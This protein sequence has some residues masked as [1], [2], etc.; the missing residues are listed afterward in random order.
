MR[1]LPHAA[2]APPPTI[3]SAAGG[4]GPARCPHVN[5]R[6]PVLAVVQPA[7]PLILRHGRP[8]A[9]AAP[10]W[11]GHVQAL[12]VAH[13]AEHE[14]AAVPQQQGGGEARVMSRGVVQARR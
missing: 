6:W 13:G 8:R 12:H 9:V 11:D 1:A 5:R 7:R 14:G 4:L 2:V 10:A 3:G